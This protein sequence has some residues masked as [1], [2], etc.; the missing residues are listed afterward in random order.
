MLASTFSNQIGTWLAP[1]VAFLAGVV[2]FASPCVL[3]LVPGYLSFISGA[4]ASTA[5]EAGVRTARRAR[6][7]PIALFIAGF[8]VVFTLLGAFSS[9]FVRLFKGTAGQ[10]AAGSVIALLG[11]LLIAYGLGRGSI[12]L[13][14]ERRPFLTK[15]RP[16]VTGAFPLGMAFAAG[17][18][19]CIGPVLG[20]IIGLAATRSAAGGAFLLVCYS[21]GL[22]VP[23]L[24]LGI[25]VQ[26]LVGTLGW[27]QRHY[28]VIAVAS[29][30]VLIAVGVLIATGWWT[31][32]VAPLLNLWPG[33]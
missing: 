1:F 2:S 32:L 11:A 16:G 10:I 19:P 17:W 23:F 4:E 31:R 24:L 3:P 12:A 18:T 27:F 33:L 21:L 14:A 7:A 28:E 13:Y 8:T 6:L 25:G 5:G 30:V 15:V 26:R 20:A 29:G 22:G 9:T